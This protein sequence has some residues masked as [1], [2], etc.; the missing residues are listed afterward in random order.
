MILFIPGGAVVYFSPRRLND[1][2]N[3]HPNAASG[4]AQA[5]VARPQWDTLRT[6]Q[7]TCSMERSPCYA[8][9]HLTFVFVLALAGRRSV[10]AGHDIS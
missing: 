2:V 1:E 9:P 10:V 4:P 6:I 5:P 7:P 8:S 3:L